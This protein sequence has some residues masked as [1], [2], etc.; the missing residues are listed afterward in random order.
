ML[1]PAESTPCASEQDFKSMEKDLYASQ[2]QP[3]TYRNDASAT[4]ESKDNI[5]EE[6]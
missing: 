2:T 5:Y 6:N 3:A 1:M 4:V